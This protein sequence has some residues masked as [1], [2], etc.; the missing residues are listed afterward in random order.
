MM[1]R[2]HTSSV[3]LLF[4]E[5]DKFILPP[6]SQR[7]FALY[8]AK[9]GVQFL[10]SPTLIIRS[11]LESHGYSRFLYS[12]PSKEGSAELIYEYAAEG[13]SNLFQGF[14]F[15]QSSDP[16]QYPCF[17]VLWRYAY[18]HP[19]PE[20][21]LHCEVVEAAFPVDDLESIK[22]DVAQENSSWK[23]SEL[24]QPLSDER[25]VVIKVRAKGTCSELG[26]LVEDLE[27]GWP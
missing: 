12:T 24:R 27:G 19:R 5:D 3:S 8:S 2:C 20:I 6:T 16:D 10:A 14:V 13:L 26:V 17:V 25:Q 9:Q 23:I 15:F 22:W 11:H 7:L 18:A 1:E 4:L 21:F